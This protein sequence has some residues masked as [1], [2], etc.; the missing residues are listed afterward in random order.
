MKRIRWASVILFSTILVFLFGCAPQST[1]ISV[2]ALQATAEEIVSQT[3]TVM[4]VPTVA[5]INTLTPVPEFTRPTPTE[6]PTATP[7]VTNTI[8]YTP[9]AVAYVTMTGDTN[10][11]LGPNTH[12]GFVTLLQAGQTVEVVGK[13]INE[14][15]WVVNN[16]NGEGTCWIW[17]AFASATGSLNRVQVMNAP[18]TL[19]PTRT[20]T[21]TPKLLAE[22]TPIP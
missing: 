19:T 5:P 20:A 8:T 15:Y 6:T 9:T 17:N 1:G 21:S 22:N 11:R 10:C 4:A 7:I 12:Y 14:N 2:E 18:A 3:E 16:P 13:D